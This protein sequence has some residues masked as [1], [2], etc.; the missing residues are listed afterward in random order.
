MIKVSKIILYQ[1][2]SVLCFSGN[3]EKLFNE[4]P[5]IEHLAETILAL[6]VGIEM[7]DQNVDDEKKYGYR[8]SIHR[9]IQYIWRIPRHKKAIKVKI[10]LNHLQC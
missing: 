9:V 10:C 5:L 4:H 2:I 7:T 3:T 1:L 8:S 6:F